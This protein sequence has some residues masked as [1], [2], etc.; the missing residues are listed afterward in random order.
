MHYEYPD[1]V[2]IT[3]KT[4]SVE[5]WT[6]LTLNGHIL[7]YVAKGRDH[8]PMK[9]VAEEAA[10]VAIEEETVKCCNRHFR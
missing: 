7:G 6:L 8:Q 5:H 1:G 10:A 3:V 2:L 9:M 4:L